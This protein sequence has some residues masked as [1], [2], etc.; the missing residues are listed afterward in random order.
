MVAKHPYY[1]VT[2]QTG[3]FKIDGIPTGTYTLEFWHEELGL[4]RKSVVITANS[5]SQISLILKND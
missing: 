2:N 3:E 4:Q 1:A 5:I